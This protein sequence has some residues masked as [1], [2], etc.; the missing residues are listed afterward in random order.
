LFSLVDECDVDMDVSPLWINVD[1]EEIIYF[2]WGELEIGKIHLAT[3]YDV[4]P[5]KFKNTCIDL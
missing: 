3:N 4:C 1:D 5:L 2:C